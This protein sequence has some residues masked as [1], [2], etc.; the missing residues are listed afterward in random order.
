MKRREILKL[1]GGAAALSPASH[2]LAAEAAASV[3]TGQFPDRDAFFFPADVCYLDSGTMHPIS[4]GAK[5]ALDQYV[6][7]RTV[8]RGRPSSFGFDDDLVREKFARLINADASEVAYVQSTTAGETLILQALGLPLKGAHVVTDTLHFFGSMPNYGELARNGVEVTWLRA[9]EGRIL[10]EDVERAVRKGTKLVAV[11][12]VST[13]NGFEHDL[14]R[15]CEIAHARGALV[16]ADIVHAAGC[17]PVDVKASG[18][19]FA[20]CASYKWLMG[21][22]GLGFLYVRKDRQAELRPPHLGYYGL[23][24]FTSHYLPL[25]PP[26]DQVV[27]YGRRQDAQ[28]LFGIG[29]YSHTGLALLNHSLDYIQRLT[30]PAIQAHAQTLITHLKQELPKLGYELLTPLEAKTPMVAC[31]MKDARKRLAAPLKEAGVRVTVGANRFRASVSV[32]N[33]MADVQRL[34]SALPRA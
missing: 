32:F 6:L 9:K 31:V 22:F 10:I 16:Y 23:S 14:K 30:V 7:N 29:T 34:L 5:A 11:S 27:D 21:D 8:Q 1:A 2:L 18:V 12:Q 33:D 4:R 3:S 20:A 26:G 17:V 28:G 19:D 25:D 15:V 24:A 13:I